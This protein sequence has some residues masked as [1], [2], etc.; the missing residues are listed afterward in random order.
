MPQ[1]ATTDNIIFRILKSVFFKSA[2]GQAGRYAKNASSLLDLLKRVLSK[3]NALS[4][5]AYAGLREK[6]GLLVRMVRMYV[7]GEYRV[8]PWKTLTRI[9][10]VLIYFLSPVDL[11]PDLLPVIGFTDDL[12]LI[13]WLFNAIQ[14]DLEAFREWD[15]KRNVVPIG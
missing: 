2:T 11:I 3:T 8:L 5:E 15:R 6:V 10:A 1:T 13:V 9:I 14:D 4:G 12:A 7:A